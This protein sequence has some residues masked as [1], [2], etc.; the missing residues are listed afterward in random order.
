M[1]CM[2]GSFRG[3]LIFASFV[4]DLAVTKF[5]HA[6]TKINAYGVMRVHDDGRGHKHHGSAANTFQ[7][8]QAIVATVI[9]L[10][11]SLTLMF[12]YLMLLNFVQVSVC[13][14]GL[15]T[16]KIANACIDYIIA[17]AA[18]PRPCTG[19]CHEIKNH[20]N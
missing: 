17:C 11:T 1:Y 2:A 8:K 19:C 12:F 6:P 3:M 16:K 4:V 5:S 18:L 15:V 7:Y 10:I 20:E 14:Y 9:Q 13:I